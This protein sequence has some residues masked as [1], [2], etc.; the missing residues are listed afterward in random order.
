MEKINKQQYQLLIKGATVLEKD[1]FGLKVL[2]TG[3]GNIIK[4]FRRKRLFSTALFLPYACRFVNNAKKLHHLGIPTITIDQLL[5]CPS[6]QRHIVVYQK[7]EGQ[8]L[9]DELSKQMNGDSDAFNKFGRFIALL[10]Q[11]GVYFRS[12]HLKNILVLPNKEF[13]LIDISDMQV[14]HRPLNLS[15]RLRNFSH[16]LRYQEDKALIHSQLDAFILGY[17]NE[18]KLSS[19]SA[20]EVENKVRALAD[21]MSEPRQ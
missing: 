18:S 4:L 2:D 14:K 3:K 7:L 11:K 19:A 15:L 1:G 12:A 9:R 21:F 10:H 5:W 17:A 16:I 13:G 6:I 8:L 20:L